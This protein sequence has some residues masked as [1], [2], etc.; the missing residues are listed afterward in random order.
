MPHP[1]PSHL[2]LDDFHPT[3]LADNS[4][5]FH[6]LVFAAIAFII[7]G[8]TKNL[9]TE[10]PILLRL[11]SPIIDRL[12]FLDLSMRPRFDLFWGGNRDPNSV[13]INRTLPFFK[14]R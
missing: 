6:S 3:L 8:R 13:I 14:E 4:S 12:R 7:F 10:E 1:L 9:G 11:E 2:G 5:V